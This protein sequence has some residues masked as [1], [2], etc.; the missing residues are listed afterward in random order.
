[1]KIK[2]LNK[3]YGVISPKKLEKYLKRNFKYYLLG[4]F[5]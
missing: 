2:N 5:F 4:L 3:L 1:M